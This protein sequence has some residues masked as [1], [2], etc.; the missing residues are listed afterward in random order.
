MGGL[1]MKPAQVLDMQ[2][3][4]LRR[5]E[6]PDFGEYIEAMMYASKAIDD[7]EDAQAKANAKHVR[8]LMG[9]HVRLADAY[10]VTDE[11]SMLVQFAASKLDDSDVMDRSMTPTPWGIVRFDRPLPIKDARGQT[12]LAH[13]LTWGQ[14]SGVQPTAFGE[15]NKAGVILSWW[16]DTVDPDDVEGRQEKAL[17]SRDYAEYK[18]CIGR[19][20]MCGTELVLDGTKL[21][22]PAVDVPL[23]S[24]ARIIAEGDTP[25]AFTNTSRY[26]HALFFL[27]NQTITNVRE[28]ELPRSAQRR[29]GK[30][31]IPGRVSVITLRRS[32]GSRHEGETMVEWS[33]RWLVRGHPAW[34]ACG[35]DHPG[36][37]PYEKGYRVRLW[38]NGYVKGPED[39]PFVVTKK[40]YNLSR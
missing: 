37:Q 24:Q 17:G 27:L 1:T 26:A 10:R 5:L 31:P 16:N 18:R 34:R 28:E 36:S 23:E 19:W 32:A 25:A 20:A 12:L 8:K 38:I 33:H 29:I 40:V 2:A 3:D 7:S 30:M 9:Q 14:A 6:T 4:L 15:V 35:K 11:M 22:G 39:A 21:G 13:W